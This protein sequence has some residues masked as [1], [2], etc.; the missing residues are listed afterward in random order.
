MLKHID[1]EQVRNLKT[2]IE[3]CPELFLP[4]QSYAEGIQNIHLYVEVIVT[5]AAE[6]SNFSSSIA[7][8][9]AIFHMI[10]AILSM[11]GL[12]IF[13]QNIW[14]SIEN[15]IEKF[16]YNIFERKM[17]SRKQ[18]VLASEGDKECEKNIHEDLCVTLDEILF[19]SRSCIGNTK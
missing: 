10:Y 1:T 18:N 8:Y 6:S 7:E 12:S 2:S 19:I 17:K 9:T 13:N 4:S 5:V 11:R 3:L 14:N 15:S 16:K